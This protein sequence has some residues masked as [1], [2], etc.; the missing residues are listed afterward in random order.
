[1][2]V[3]CSKWIVQGLLSVHLFECV[4]SGLKRFIF[5]RLI[6]GGRSFLPRT[7]FFFSFRG[8]DEYFSSSTLAVD[9]L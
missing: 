2:F 5:A 6:G 9:R 8:S 7:V 3:S 4:Q 1:M